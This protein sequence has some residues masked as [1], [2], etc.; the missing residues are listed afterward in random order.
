MSC[1]LFQFVFV[2][3]SSLSLAADEPSN[4]RTGR[5]LADVL[6]EKIGWSG[7]GVSAAKL[8]RQWQTQRR[9][10]VLFD[11]RLDPNRVVSVATGFSSGSHVL[12]QICES[13]SDVTWCASSK[14]VYV[15]PATSSDRLLPLLDLHQ[16][17]V[18]ALRGR[19][20]TA[21]FR[22][23]TA[24][25][26]QG[27]SRL[28]EP[29]SIVTSAAEQSG[30]TI[31]NPELIPHDLWDAAG[32]PRM[33]FVE[34][35]TIVLNQF[36]LMLI[37][38]SKP[39]TFRIEP[40][41]TSQSLDRSYAFGRERREAITKAY[42]ERFPELE[43][44]WAAGNLKVSA[45]LEQHAWFAALL[46]QQSAAAAVQ[47]AVPTESLRTRR[48]SLETSNATVGQLIEHFRSNGV[49]MEVS[50]ADSDALQVVLQQEIRLNLKSVVGTEFFQQAFGT[51]FS[52]VAVHD[53]RVVLTL[54]P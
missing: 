50:A 24:E 34:L 33:S 47:L 26:P 5:E 8:L 19:L 31:Q 22:K 9:V 41:D 53:Q 54:T 25:Y 38:G 1:K 23:L 15:G 35:A 37:P 44:Q 52:S 12:Q 45:S 13:L 30:I 11:R 20:P 32:L 51:H 6:N 29:R 36:D 16:Q 48:F 27:W 3:V 14:W 28:S 42:R 7:S 17:H 18:M 4:F 46:R 21:S 43:A 40:I 49:A 39:D 10:A 2:M